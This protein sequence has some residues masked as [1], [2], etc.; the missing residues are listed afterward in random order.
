[1]HQRMADSRWVV[2]ITVRPWAMARMVRLMMASDLEL[3]QAMRQSRVI[4]P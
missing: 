4:M 3:T 2:M 1:M